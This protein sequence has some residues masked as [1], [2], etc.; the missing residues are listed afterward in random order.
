MT[1]ALVLQVGKVSLVLGL[2]WFA[3]LDEGGGRA[4]R[5]LARRHRAT[6]MIATGHAAGAV[7]VVALP[8]Y[9]GR[10]HTR[11]PR[12]ARPAPSDSILH[13]AAMLFARQFPAGTVAALIEVSPGLLW[14][15]AVHEGVVVARTDRLYVDAAA[16]LG[17]MAELKLAYPHLVTPGEGA[18]PAV[19][20]LD[21]PTQHTGAHSQ[22]L[23]LSDWRRLSFGTQ[24]G[25]GLMVILA[26]CAARLN[27][28]SYQIDPPSHKEP[29][30][31]WLAPTSG[32]MLPAASPVVHGT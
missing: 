30:T 19:P 3:L 32:G 28:G 21:A 6:H 31:S 14:L 24:L 12:N 8:Q 25:L 15:I 22:L 27:A 5:R 2:E 7:G 20:G 4:A 23:P 18:T 17:A 10:N 13:S 1:E 9:R 26:L 11:A 16:A 29:A